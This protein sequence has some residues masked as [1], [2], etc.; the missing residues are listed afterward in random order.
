[1]GGALSGRF[2][3]RYESLEEDLNK[4]LADADIKQR[5]AV[6]KVNV[7][8]NKDEARE[9][10][11]IIHLIH[12]GC[13]TSSPTGTSLKSRCWATDFEVVGPGERPQC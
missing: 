3:G 9:I 1:V 5:I 13:A 12:P 6:P 8:P 2:L 10:A 11:L 4:T 7:A